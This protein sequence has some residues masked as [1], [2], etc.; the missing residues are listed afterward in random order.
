MLVS[1]AEEKNIVYPYKKGAK[2]SSG[3]PPSPIPTIANIFPRS[4]FSGSTVCIS[5]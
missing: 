1:A 4:C 5:C 2:N 3:T